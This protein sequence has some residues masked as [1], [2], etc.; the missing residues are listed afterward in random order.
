MSAK[1]IATRAKH[2][3]QLLIHG[4]GPV[5]GRGENRVF[6]IP[7]AW[8]GSSFALYGLQRGPHNSPHVGRGLFCCRQ[9]HRG[10]PGRS[11]GQ[12]RVW[13]YA[14]CDCRAPRFTICA[15]PPACS[16]LKPKSPRPRCTSRRLPS[17]GTMRKWTSPRSKA[18]RTSKGRRGLPPQAATICCCSTREP[19]KSSS[20]ARWAGW[21]RAWLKPWLAGCRTVRRSKNRAAMCASAAWS[22]RARRPPRCPGSRTASRSSP[23]TSET[24]RTATAFAQGAKGAIL[25]HTAGLIHPRRIAE[26]YSVNVRGAAQLLDAGSPRRRQARRRGLLELPLRLQPAPRPPVR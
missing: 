21:G 18:R 8:R 25:F 6:I 4:G 24:R 9:R 17:A 20:P 2:V 7:T 23:A 15:E 19:I 3:S 16:K 14:H 13:G 5:R 26:L 11:G 1:R 22:C 12:R 10:L